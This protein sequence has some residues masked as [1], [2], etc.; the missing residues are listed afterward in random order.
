MHVFIPNEP[1]K[2]F[3][4]VC[5]GETYQWIIA[6]KTAFLPRLHCT[7]HSLKIY[8]LGYTDDRN[9]SYK[10]ETTRG[11]L[12]IDITLIFGSFKKQFIHKKMDFSWDNNCASVHE[13]LSPEQ[14]YFVWRGLCVCVT[15]KIRCIDSHI[16]SNLITALYSYSHSCCY[17][18]N[19]LFLHPIDLRMSKR[20]LRLAMALTTAM[21]L[22]SLSR[23][24]NR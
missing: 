15:N 12:N 8:I 14:I 17:Y 13:S 1:L 21:W 24:G 20:G 6:I 3:K 7:G 11:C 10:F 22:V 5:E 4:S 2:D 23:W 19:L 18:V 9:K 16:N